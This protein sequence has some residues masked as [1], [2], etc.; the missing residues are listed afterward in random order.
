MIHSHQMAVVLAVVIFYFDSLA[1]V[2]NL[3]VCLGLTGR[4][5]VVLGHT[6][7]TQTLTKPDEQRN[8]IK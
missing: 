1:G 2:S 8:G 7:N 4:R 6:L 5:R 3:L